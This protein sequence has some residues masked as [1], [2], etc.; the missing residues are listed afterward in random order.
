MNDTYTA[1]DGKI[2]SNNGANHEVEASYAEQKKDLLVNLNPIPLTLMGLP[3]FPL[4][5]VTVPQ[6]LVYASNPVQSPIK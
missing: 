2:E 5:S 1:C 6:C 3:Q 4:A